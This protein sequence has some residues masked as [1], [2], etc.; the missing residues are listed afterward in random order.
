MSGVT[1]EQRGHFQPQ[2]Q[3]G[4]WAAPWSPPDTVENAHDQQAAPTHVYEAP[5]NNNA[6]PL[7]PAPVADRA[8]PA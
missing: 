6:H 8:D 2:T 3:D 7:S 4:S 5:L 1:P